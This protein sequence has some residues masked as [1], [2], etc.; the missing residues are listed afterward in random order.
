MRENKSE[1]ERIFGVSVS[2]DDLN[3]VTERLFDESNELTVITGEELADRVPAVFYAVR[4]GLSYFAVAVLAVFCLTVFIIMAFTNF[5]LTGWLCGVTMSLAGL[6][7]ILLSSFGITDLFGR[8][9]VI[10]R[11]SLLVRSVFSASLTYSVIITV[12][13]VL[14]IVSAIVSIIINKNKARQIGH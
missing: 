14:L 2:S 11:V 10:Y 8:G 1:I 7:C 5:S 6:A 3:S 4:Y 9:S 12:I 13:G